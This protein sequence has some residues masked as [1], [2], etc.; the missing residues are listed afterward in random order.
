MG[1]HP[2]CP[3]RMDVSLCTFGFSAI[4]AHYRYCV[5][6]RAIT[7]L[8]AWFE[9]TLER[10]LTLNE[11]F[12]GLSD[13]KIRRYNNSPPYVTARWP[14]QQI[15]PLNIFGQ[16]TP[17]VKVRSHYTAFTLPCRYIDY[18]LPQVTTASSHFELKWTFMRH[19][20][21]VTSQYLCRRV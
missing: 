19:R 9:S 15:P 2:Y 13:E 11:I 1:R 7:N 3:S 18:F 8:R 17:G 20:N 12:G 14:P 5:I 4:C 16:A 10:Q 6:H 21:A